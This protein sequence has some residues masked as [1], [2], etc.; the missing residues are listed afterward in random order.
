[1]QI[2][3]RQITLSDGSIAL[4]QNQGMQTFGSI[5]VQAS[6]SVTLTG[7]APDG[8]VSSSFRQ[9]TLGVGNTGDI[10]VSTRQLAIREGGQIRNRT[11]GVGNTGNLDV[12][13]SESI[14]LSGAS[15]INPQARSVIANFSLDRGF[16]GD[17]VV[18]TQH[19]KIR[20]GA[21]ISTTA[22]GTGSGGD[23][24][25]NAVE[26]I[27]VI[28]LEPRIIAASA[29]ASTS[30]G[31]GNAGSVT[32]NTARAI[33][34]DGGR[35]TSATVASGDGG[36]VVVNATEFVEVSGT[37]P[38]S[39]NPSLIDASANQVDEVT[40][41]A[42]G[43]P[44]VPSG[45]PGNVEI[46]TPKFRVTDG[47]LV[48]VR[49]DG[50]GRAGSLQVNADT[51]LLDEGGITAS[52][53]SGEGGN[54]NLQIDESLQLR[55]GSQITA[56]AGGSGNGGNLTLSA[57]SIALLEGS[58]ID[59]N[60]FEGRGGN[61][62]ITTQGL[63]LSPDS[64]I[65]A[66][67]QLGIDGLVTISQPEIDT[68]AAFVQLNSDPIDPT[69]QIVSACGVAH[70]NSFIVTGNGGLP[71]DPTDVLRGQNIWVDMRLLEIRELNRSIEDNPTEEEN[72]SFVEPTPLV[73]ATG[74]DVKADGTVEL[75]AIPPRQTNDRGAPS[76]C[77][78][79][80]DR[81][82]VSIER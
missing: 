15:P 25:V 48:T 33:V 3:G 10:A 9:E 44:P 6:E 73:E 12:R 67:S 76:N 49:N 34:R 59:A 70:E 63:F 43:L 41:Q 31:I 60:A 46:N 66:S 14:E 23:V 74:W 17:L 24:L 61:I 27:E 13:A 39:I 8:I 69:T 54:I 72:S 80:R 65:T 57:N 18:S 29:I 77:P 7:T 64:H 1:M 71:P 37:V 28:G 40:Q 56:E 4:L 35:I 19:L 26:T 5:Q 79:Y 42:F 21:S 38:S 55:H 52:T 78:P 50:M 53:R 32:V 2:V 11:Q 36:R 45:A 68:S 22:L 82:H 16:V 51:I 81:S 62:E 75:V 47:G 58:T 30:L 20:G